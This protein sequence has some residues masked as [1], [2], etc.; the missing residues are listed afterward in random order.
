MAMTPRLGKVALC[1]PAVCANAWLARAL[2]G[3][4]VIVVLMNPIQFGRFRRRCGGGVKAVKAA[5]TTVIMITTAQ[6]LAELDKVMILQNGAV[7]SFGPRD[8]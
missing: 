1:C 6:S 3:D 7:Q 8:G 4:P 2:Y 5:G